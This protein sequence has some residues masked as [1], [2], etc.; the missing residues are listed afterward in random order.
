MIAFLKYQ[1]PGNLR[2]LQNVIKRATLLNNSNLLELESLPQELILNNDDNNGPSNLKDEAEKTA[3]IDALRLAKGN[4][5]RAAE[6]LGISRK[7]LYDKINQFG[8]DD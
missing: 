1:W 8:L 3:I 6:L 2:E 5:S 7:T 4:K